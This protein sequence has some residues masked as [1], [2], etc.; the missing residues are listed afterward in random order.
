MVAPRNKNAKSASKTTSRSVKSDSTKST[1]SKSVKSSTKSAAKAKAAPVVKSKK[2]VAPK[3]V[4]ADKATKVENPPQP[5][6]LD[7]SLKNDRGVE[8]RGHISLTSTTVAQLQRA[9]LLQN[10]AKNGHPSSLK[11]YTGPSSANR[12]RLQDQAALADTMLL[13]SSPVDTVIKSGMGCDMLRTFLSATGKR[14]MLAGATLHM[15]VVAMNAPYGKNKASQVRRQLFND[16]KSDLQTL[17]MMKTGETDR[18]KVHRD[19]L[20]ARGLNAMQA[21]R[22]GKQGLIDGILIG[23]DQIIVRADMDAFFKKKKWNEEQ[24]QEFLKHYI[25]VYQLPT[26]TLREYAPV[27]VPEGKLVFYKSLKKPSND[28]KDASKDGEPKEATPAIALKA[29]PSKV[30]KVKGKKAVAESVAAPVVAKGPADTPAEEKP[31]TPVFYIGEKKLDELPMVTKA[32][33]DKSPARIMVDVVPKSAN[34]IL[35]DDVIFFNDGFRDETA[36]QIA[37]SLLALEHKKLQSG[38]KT[39][40]KIIENSPG[41]SVWSGQELRS[42]IKSLKTPVDIIV[43]GMGASCGS[44]L[45]CSATGNRYATPHARIM[46]HEAANE[47][48]DLTPADHF[49]EMHD[50]LDQAT[51][52]Y[53]SIVAEATGRPYD[54]VLQD[55]DHDVWLNPLEALFYGTKG[56]IDAILVGHNRVILR[57][58]VEKYLLKHFGSASR[59]KQYLIDKIEEKRDPRQAMEWRPERHKED[60]PFDNPLKIIQAV[61]D[62]ASRPMAE[63]P[64]FRLSLPD[65][66]AP[67]RTIDFFNVVIDEKK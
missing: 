39:H 18:V 4:K 55:F 56:L 30:K 36:E 28:K 37:D 13:V 50:G 9:L 67:E 35:D 25:N 64:R 29:D 43:Q 15:G 53:I 44:W 65:I 61:A 6:V 5:V 8:I 3:P 22:Y 12:Y 58:D 51:L 49:N 16:Y 62:T 54:E 57:E 20:S 52:D 26:R 32:S 17:V 42:V 38:N 10:I 40:I 14:Y 31:S 19:L 59:L 24:V 21:L 45:L 34:G 11:F 1:V 2:S 27:S 33:K 63:I 46:F 48:R 66:D 41:G 47:L 23:H 60:D 7:Q